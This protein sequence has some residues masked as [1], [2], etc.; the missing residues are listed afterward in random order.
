MNFQHKNEAKSWNY[1]VPIVLISITPLGSDKLI[2]VYG[3][4]VIELVII[5]G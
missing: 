2:K 3:F 4:N 5:I 1:L